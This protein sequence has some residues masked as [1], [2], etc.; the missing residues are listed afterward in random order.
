MVSS[1]GVR[2]IIISF[3]SLALLGQNGAGKSTSM[4]ILSGLTPSTS[5]DA[6]VYGFSVKSQMHEIEKIMG[7]CPQHD[8]LFNDLT[9]KEHID[10]YG[11]LKGLTQ[12]EI[13]KV[14]EE[15]L[16]AVKLWKVR[17]QRSAAYSGGMKRRL[18]MVIST[19]GEPKIV[20]LDEPTTGISKLLV[21]KLNF[22]C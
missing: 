9:A 10:L 6:L 21:F 22:V 2:M 12:E 20:Y 4:N 14:C 5:G 18:S 3:S 13:D 8:I 11:G 19:I 16:S 15:R 17:D 1:N 7:V